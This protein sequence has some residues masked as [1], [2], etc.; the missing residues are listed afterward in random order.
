MNARFGFGH[1]ELELA[2]GCAEFDKN[3][4]DHR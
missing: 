4:T 3:R 1:F 2:G